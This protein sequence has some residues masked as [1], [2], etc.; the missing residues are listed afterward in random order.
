M[1]WH[2]PPNSFAKTAESCGNAQ[3]NMRQDPD[4]NHEQHEPLEIISHSGEHLLK[5]INDVLEIAKIEAG[6][7]QLEK[8]TVDLHSLVREVVDMMRLRA[9]Q[10]GLQLEL[11]Q[12]SDFPRYSM[13]D[14]ARLR[15]IL[16]NLVGNAIKFTEHGGVTI[17]LSTRHNASQSLLLEIEDTGPGIDAQDQQRLFDPFVQLPEGKVQIGTGLGLSIVKQFVQLM[18]GA[19][20]LDSRPGKG[21]RF[22][23][24]LPLE[25]TDE[26]DS[27]HL[28]EKSHGEVTGLAPGQPN[29]R[30]LIAEDQEDNRLLL[31]RLMHN[32]GLET[33][34]ARNGEE[35]V[36]IFKEWQPDLIW[37][38]RRMPVMDG[39]E[40]TSRIRDLPGGDKVKIVAVTASVFKEQEPTPLANGIDEYIRKPFQFNDIYDSL[41]RH[42]GLKFL[43]RD[44]APKGEYAPERLSPQQLGAVPDELRAELETAAESLDNGRIAA[45]IERI[46][47][48]DAELG[49]TLLRLADKFDYPAIL[50][51]LRNEA[52]NATASDE[53]TP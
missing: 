44:E 12:S 32:I 52:R 29:Y 51:A 5:L 35:C 36:Q 25:A 15:Q 31:S 40:A 8:T 39:M 53:K 42:L 7:M 6:K 10:K 17:R 18:G 3:K 49:K 26:E 22:S 9:Q 50:T 30:I 23:V 2:T 38:D 19:I 27:A 47:A 1:K 34:T 16:I 33:R 46:N 14:E 13:G 4:L 45:V 43:Y 41:A 21:S 37:M 28:T 24:E 20:T 48:I 11:V